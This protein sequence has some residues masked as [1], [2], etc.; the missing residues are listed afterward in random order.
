MKINNKIYFNISLVICVI[1]I[2]VFSNSLFSQNQPSYL[3][4][5]NKISAAKTARSITAVVKTNI[6]P[7][8]KGPL[9]YTGEYRIVGEMLVAY[10]H[11]LSAGVGYLGK[12]LMYMMQE[13]S[14]SFKSQGYTPLKISGYRI[15]VQYKYYFASKEYSCKGFYVSPCLSYGRARYLDKNNPNSGDKIIG[16]KYQGNALLGFQMAIKNKFVVDLFLGPGYKSNIMT[17]YHKSTGSQKM[18]TS[19]LGLFFN[20][21]FSFVLGLNFGIAL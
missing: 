2:V 21:N 6:L 12:G 10:K 11:S 5:E 18:D 20:S 13:N 1:F 3:K 19:G 9:L 7:I 15:Q 4:N 17:E 16:E 14:Q 8:F